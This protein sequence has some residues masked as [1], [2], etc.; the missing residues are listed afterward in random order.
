MVLK[1]RS[2]YFP[3]RFHRILA[4]E[5]GPVAGQGVAQKPR[6]GQVRPACVVH[7]HKLALIAD[8]IKVLGVAAQASRK[9]LQWRHATRLGTLAPVL[10]LRHQLFR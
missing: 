6:V 9:A 1:H 5:Q 3:R 10:H 4:I 8:E 2:D 7:Q